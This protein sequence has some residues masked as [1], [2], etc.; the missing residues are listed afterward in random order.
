LILSSLLFLAALA[1]YA[2]ARQPSLEAADV[3]RKDG[4]LEEAASMYRKYSLQHP[5]SHEA[6][7]FLGL[8]L[9]AAERPDEA[10]SL[11]RKALV[12][13]PRL[14]EAYMNAASIYSTMESRAYEAYS[15]YRHA[16]QLREWSPVVH[17]HAEFN[18]ALALQDLDRGTEA[19]SALRRSQELQPSFEPAIALLNELLPSG[20][21]ERNSENLSANGTLPPQKASS[22][23]FDESH[24]T[25]RS[26][27]TAAPADKHRC[28]WREPTHGGTWEETQPA[29]ALS[30]PTPLHAAIVNLQS[31]VRL[32]LAEPAQSEDTSPFKRL[33]PAE[34]AAAADLVSDLGKLLSRSVRRGARD[35]ES[36]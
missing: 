21:D 35:E 33:A 27:D 34:V 18:S 3:L 2:G 1:S 15:S 8:T 11:Y 6:F 5:D 20:T 32:A 25:A 12:L 10:L 16:L 36:A 28:T 31:E 14:A 13:A 24:A 9:R 22:D 4:A 26:S 7:F 29:S 23:S 19:I 17:A 30:N